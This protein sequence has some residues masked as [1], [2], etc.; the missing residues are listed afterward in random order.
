MWLNPEGCPE[1]AAVPLDARSE[2][3]QRPRYASAIAKA[4]MLRYGI[5]LA[6]GRGL[7]VHAV[8]ERQPSSRSGVGAFTHLPAVNYGKQLRLCLHNRTA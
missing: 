4:L 6:H 1:Q 2:A 7:G 3:E 8:R 5:E